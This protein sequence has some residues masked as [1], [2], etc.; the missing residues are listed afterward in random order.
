[1]RC[2]TL[3]LF[4]FDG[5]CSDGGPG[6]EFALC[7]LGDD[8]DDCGPRMMHNPPPSPPPPPSTPPPPPSP[9]PPPSSPPLPPS[10]PVP[11]SA[12]PA[13]PRG[14]ISAD[15]FPLQYVEAD[16]FGGDDSENGDSFGY[17]VAISS[18][19]TVF[20]GAP[21]RSR[22]GSLDIGAAYIYFPP[23]QP[24]SLPPQRPP[25]QQPPLPPP[26]PFQPQ[27][28]WSESA[29]SSLWTIWIVSASVLFGAGIFMAYLILRAYGEGR[30]KPAG[31]RIATSATSAALTVR[32]ALPV[33]AAWADPI[34][35]S[36]ER[37][38]QALPAPRMPTLLVGVP[39]NGG[40]TSS[41]Y[42]TPSSWGE[43]AAARV[44]ALAAA[45]QSRP[46]SVASTAQSRDVSTTS[47]RP[48]PRQ[49]GVQA[50][51]SIQ[52]SWNDKVELMSTGSSPT[53]GSPAS[54]RSKSSNASPRSQ[55]AK[56]KAPEVN[57]QSKEQWLRE[58]VFV[59][60]ELQELT[61]NQ[62]WPSGRELRECP[63][64]VPLHEW[65]GVPESDLKAAWQSAETSWQRLKG[66]AGRDTAY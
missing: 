33:P 24:P 15:L 11:P 6:A 26:S 49:T 39:P 13:Q 27:L 44:A 50:P 56:G 43:M 30:L 38:S 42:Q 2:T 4:A 9:S 21:S 45:R 32:Q 65:L 17:S 20:I 46:G 25:P 51:P 64:D 52:V 62:P 22:N 40:S 10:P 19:G 23:F 63:A 41:V 61:T 36:M 35:E 37:A 14:C 60:L 34:V 3:C 66:R 18:T 8:C 29:N 58:V 54:P 5:T 59:Q 57:P 53:A 7:K 16:E 55:R 12:P 1:M 48:P 31:A 28:L 47:R